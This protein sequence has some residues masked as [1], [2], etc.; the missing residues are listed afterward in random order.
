MG[1]P[2]IDPEDKPGRDWLREFLKANGE[3]VEQGPVEQVL[4]NPQHDYTKRLLADVPRLHG[5]VAVLTKPN[6]SQ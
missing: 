6:V 5:W 2:A 4:A 3:L 1:D